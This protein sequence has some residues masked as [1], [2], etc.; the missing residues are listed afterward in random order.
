MQMTGKKYIPALRFNF[1]TPLYDAVMKYLM[2]EDEFKN[3]LIEQASIHPNQ[4][5]LDFGCGTATLT[6]MAKIKNPNAKII[7][8][9][10][11]ENIIKISKEKISA[12]K[13]DIKTDTY[14][15]NTLTYENET[16]DRIISCLV[17][18]HIPK[19]RKEATLKDL[20]RI[21][22]K[23]GELH[24]ADFGKPGNIIMSAISFILQFLEPSTLKD[25]IAGRI[26][27]E[28]E[29]AGFKSAKE[30]AH[31]NTIFGTVALYSARK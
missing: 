17:M 2:H 3:A 7:G 9:D 18:H 1:L 6:I 23:G 15:G 5:V 16:F 21:L 25:N 11:D 27:A 14:D 4:N 10:I 22:K 30:T 24:I 13:L 20:H 26:P 8:I 12:M 29:T 31:Y 28:L 19:D